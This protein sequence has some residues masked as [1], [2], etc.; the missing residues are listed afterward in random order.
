MGWTITLYDKDGNELVSFNRSAALE[1]NFMRHGDNASPIVRHPIK[2]KTVHVDFD[3]AVEV[4]AVDAFHSYTM[5]IIS[6]RKHPLYKKGAN[7]GPI[8]VDM[9][10]NPY[11][12]D[13]P[14][15][16]PPPNASELA[17]FDIQ[18]ARLAKMEEQFFQVVKASNDCPDG[19]WHF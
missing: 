3:Q 6:I 9:W 15:N 12:A 16:H 4:D 11:F 7:S 5:D 19:Y 18:A 13:K 10:G 2:S 1:Q 17:G 8:R 14:F